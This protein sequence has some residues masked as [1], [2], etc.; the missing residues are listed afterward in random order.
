MHGPESAGIVNWLLNALFTIVIATVGLIMKS[1]NR[2]VKDVERNN[3][4]IDNRLVA[5]ENTALTEERIRKI[6]YEHTEPINSAHERIF[7]KLNGMSETM[8]KI[9]VQQ[10]KING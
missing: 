9:Q 3:S 2:R 4:K 7:E 5:V 10:A 8:V 6:M 1:L